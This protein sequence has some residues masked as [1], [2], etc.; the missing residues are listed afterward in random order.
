M[1]GK[2]IT[3]YPRRQEPIG[4]P[5]VVTAVSGSDV[6][7]ILLLNDQRRLR[8]SALQ[9]LYTLVDRQEYEQQTDEVGRNTP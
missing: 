9:L 4:Q 1:L 3:V 8:G 7:E 2:N 5:A 6:T